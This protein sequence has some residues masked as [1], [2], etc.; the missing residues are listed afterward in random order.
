MRRG[1]ARQREGRYAAPAPTGA[2]AA[3]IAESGQ[4]V[5]VAAIGPLAEYRDRARRTL[6]HEVHV[7]TPLAECEQREV[8]VGG[9]A[10][11][12][13][14]VGPSGGSAAENREG[15]PAGTDGVT[16][17][18]RASTFG[19]AGGDLLRRVY[20]MQPPL[21]P[22]EVSGDGIRFAVDPG[23]DRRTYGCR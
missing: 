7:D 4:I 2:L 16:Q 1:S 18:R 23:A 9:P 22:V 13:V 14:T 6:F 5:L 17:R 15:Q 3:M 12:T 19:A 10:A 8:E 21:Y 20:R 11:S